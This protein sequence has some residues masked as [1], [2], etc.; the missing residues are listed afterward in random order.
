MT[1]KEFLIVMIATLV[2]VVS[3]VVFGIIHARAEIKETPN[4]E[5]L[6][7]PISPNFDLEGLDLNE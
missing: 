4:L 6:T 7:R 2:T 5:E 3:W 1:R